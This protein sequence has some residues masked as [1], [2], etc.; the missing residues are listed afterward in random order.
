MKTTST[1]LPTDIW[2]IASWDEYIE[3]IYDRAYEKARSYYYKRRML[4]ETMPTGYDRSC[5]RG[6]ILFAVN[7]FC[8]IKGI[9]LNGLIACSF[10]QV[11]H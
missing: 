4:I 7:L 11:G 2:A 3:S 5:D 6:M 9:P 8:M 10:R 1:K